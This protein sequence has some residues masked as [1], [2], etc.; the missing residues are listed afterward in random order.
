MNTSIKAR[1]CL[2]FAAA[3][4]LVIAPAWG[5]ESTRP[6]PAAGVAAAKAADSVVARPRAAA[7]AEA[8]A[9]RVKQ[10]AQAEKPKA[11]NAKPHAIRRTPRDEYGVVLQDGSYSLFYN[12]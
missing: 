12:Y 9:A 5:A 4:G 11:A 6:T 3:L 7:T 8:E 10:P 2:L 1:G